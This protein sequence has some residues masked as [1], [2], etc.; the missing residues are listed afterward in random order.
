MRRPQLRATRRN[1]LGTPGGDGNRNAFVQHVLD[2]PQHAVV[3]ALREDHPPRG[4]PGAVEDRPHEKTG[5]IDETRKPRAVGLD[6][7]QRP[8]GDAAL[9]GGPGH[10]RRN[11]PE[12]ARIERP[13]QQVVPA[14][15]QPAVAIGAGDLV[16]DA[17]ARQLRQ[18]PD[19]GK[20]HIA[21]DPGCADIERPAE[22]EGEAEHIVDLV[23]II[24]PAGKDD[25][26]GAHGADLFR[27]DLRH[28][29]GERHD[30]GVGPH[31]PHLVR[32]QHIRPGEAQEYL[33]PVDDLV[34]RAGAAVLREG[35]LVGFGGAPLADQ[36]VY[37]HQPDIL[38]LQPHI[39]QHVQAGDAGR[40]AAGRD[41]L[42]PPQVLAEQV[43]A[44][45]D[46]G[47]DH[48]GRAVLV[49][50]EDGNVHLRLQPVLDQEAVG[51]LD[52]LQVD[53]AEGRFEPPDRI[54]ERV[55]VALADFD[56]EHVDIGEF[57]EQDGLAFHDGLGRQRA[58]IAEP[59]HRRAVR[60]HRHKVGPRRVARGVLRAF[61]DRPAR[62]GDARRVGQRQVPLVGQRL[63][64]A[65]GELA[66][67]S[68]LV[69]AQCVPV[70]LPTSSPA[71]RSGYPDAG[72][73]PAVSGCRASPECARRPA[74]TGRCCRHGRRPQR[75]L[76]RAP[77]AAPGR[78]GRSGSGRA[79]SEADR[80]TGV[81]AWRTC[82]GM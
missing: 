49:V 27:H 48:D 28:R 9:H 13:R 70:H 61:G 23:R 5:A 24:A 72:P 63:G 60:H 7:G 22:D 2:R 4:R 73:A 11:R 75:P 15:L 81:S 66:G 10:R 16:G 69:I 33:R 32:A 62:L 46:R 42:D 38:A 53:G 41:E 79:P 37:V 21:V 43:H 54:G 78:N 57:L 36:P 30:H 35:G 8:R 50:V 26:V 1:P 14:E 47:G 52:V 67:P 45:D 58:D 51:R 3:L 6:V 82:A 29:V 74:R 77:G 55:G 44:V 59:E 56:V 34:E 31:A 40:A 65:D 20:L 76:R 71:K 64:R 80:R 39:E 18:R 68:R 17:L 19:A 25:G 12:Q